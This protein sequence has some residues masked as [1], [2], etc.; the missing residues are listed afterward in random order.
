MA[1]RGRAQ[2]EEASSVSLCQASVV[3]LPYR[4]T[5]NEVATVP[6]IAVVTGAS[7]MNGIG[8]AIC[9]E[10]ARRGFAIFFT[11]WTPF[12]ER[13]GYAAGGGPAALAEELADLGPVAHMPL[14]LAEPGS[15]SRLIDTVENQLGRP[16]VLVNNAAHWE[17]AS[18]RDLTEAIIDAHMAVNVRG[19]LML[20]A[21]FARRIQND[22]YGRIISLVSGQ[23]HHGE[24]DNLPYGATKG[25]ISAMT[26]Y[27]AVELAP[28]NITVNALDPGPTDTGWMEP[29]VKEGI[30][31]MSPMGRI[32]QPEDAARVVAF[33]ASEEAQW[34]T[35]QVI[36][37]DG[38]F[39]L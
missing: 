17:S 10:L 36:R 28:L 11:H 1:L 6:R 22:G 33:L 34:V 20:S 26:R 24:P 3:A 13:T 18:F 16:S 30:R 5:G 35:G 12:D 4:Q 37:A 8:A 29:E 39:P 19:T 9:R 7:R 27:L 32:G 38:G 31:Q 25:A 14:N 15:A 21:E 2:G 23:D